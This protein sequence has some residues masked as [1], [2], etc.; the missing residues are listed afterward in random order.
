MTVCKKLIVSMLALAGGTYSVIG[1]CSY[2]N[3]IESIALYYAFL[4]SFC[5]ALV[6]FAEYK[7]NTR[8]SSRGKE[9]HTSAKYV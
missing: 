5:S 2:S 8:L 4:G 7:Y 3:V 9:N 1:C 6:I